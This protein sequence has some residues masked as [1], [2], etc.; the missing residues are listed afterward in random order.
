M[1]DGIC[2]VILWLQMQI[3]QDPLFWELKLNNKAL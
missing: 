3:Y 1:G 2:L